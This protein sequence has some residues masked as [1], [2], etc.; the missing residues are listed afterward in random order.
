MKFT[1]SSRVIPLLFLTLSGCG[2]FSA[3]KAP[4]MIMDYEEETAYT[5]TD[6]ALLGEPVM[7]EQL[8]TGEELT[9]VEIVWSSPATKAEGFIL[10]YGY[11]A[12]ELP[13]QK[14]VPL[15]TI[16]RI[17]LPQGEAFR[18]VISGTDPDKTLYVKV[19]EYS[20]SVVSSPSQAFEVPPLNDKGKP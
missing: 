14:K 6:P 10:Q 15:K 16:E 2:Y 12:N 4:Q 18:T 9:D 13:L 20:G 17:N 19:S 8:E 7:I 5:G 11:A 3:A 1:S